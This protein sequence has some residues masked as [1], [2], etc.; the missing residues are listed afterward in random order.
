MKALRNLEKST[1]MPS[2][3]I[4]DQGDVFVVAR[5]DGLG[6]MRQR[7][8]HHLEINSGQDEPLGAP[9]VGMNKAVEGEPFVA[10]LHSNARSRPFAYPH[11]AQDRFQTDAM[12]VHRPHFDAGLGVLQVNQLDILTQFF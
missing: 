2:S 12:F 3:L 10:L 1:G 9:R 4:K 7:Q 6:K 5:T 11:P 8:V